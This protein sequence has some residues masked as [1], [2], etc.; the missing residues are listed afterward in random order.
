[1]HT[2][3]GI[4]NLQ[5]ILRLLTQTD[6][7]HECFLKPLHIFFHY[8]K[9]LDLL[10]FIELWVFDVHSYVDTF[11]PFCGNFEIKMY[12]VNAHVFYLKNRDKTV[13]VGLDCFQVGH[14][15]GQ[16]K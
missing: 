5:D 3:A 12:F 2:H 1:M 13:P 6:G 16:Y 9:T 4:G 14:V 15:S 11:A 8:I 10:F 7:V